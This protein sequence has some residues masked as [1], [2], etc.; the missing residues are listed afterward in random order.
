MPF[1]AFLFLSMHRGLY[2]CWGSG[3][4]FEELHVRRRTGEKSDRE[5]RARKKGVFKR[6]TCYSLGTCKLGSLSFSL[7]FSL[8]SLSL[9][10]VC[11]YVCVCVCVCV[12]AHTRTAVRDG[13][14]CLVRRPALLGFR[15]VLLRAVRPCCMRMSISRPS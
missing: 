11:V 5:Q 1:Y 7:S 2:E 10:C 13:L 8:F 14:C 4:T 9:S 15:Q 6:V 12:H 3:A